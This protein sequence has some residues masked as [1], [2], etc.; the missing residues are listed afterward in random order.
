MVGFVHDIIGIEIFVMAH[1]CGHFSPEIAQMIFAYARAAN[2]E[3]F[4]THVVATE[5]VH[6]EDDAYA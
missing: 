5:I 6:A 1:F 2:D 3:L 4:A